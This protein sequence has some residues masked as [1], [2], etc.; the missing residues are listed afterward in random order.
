MCLYWDLIIITHEAFKEG[1]YWLHSLRCWRQRTHHQCLIES[2]SNLSPHREQTRQRMDPWGKETTL[3]VDSAYI[4]EGCG[5]NKILEEPHTPDVH[6]YPHEVVLSVEVH[7]WLEAL[8]L[9]GIVAT[10]TKHRA[11]D[12]E[13]FTNR[14][15]HL[16][17]IYYFLLYLLYSKKPA[18][19]RST[20]TSSKNSYVLTNTELY[21]QYD[22]NLKHRELKLCKKS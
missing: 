11:P 10:H 5:W 17:F 14:P 21:S 16:F 6:V 22:E 9:A 20:F 19:V 7:V 18:H 2:R 4:Q 12:G 15:D 1:E 13:V 3:K 8:P